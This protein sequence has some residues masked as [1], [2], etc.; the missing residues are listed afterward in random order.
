MLFPGKHFYKVVLN[1]VKPYDFISIPTYTNIC[2]S[3]AIVKVDTLTV[4]TGQL[5]TQS[6]TFVTALPCSNEK[7]GK[8]EKNHHG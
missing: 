3:I 7:K 4:E 6:T 8:Y 2:N 5:R 1:F